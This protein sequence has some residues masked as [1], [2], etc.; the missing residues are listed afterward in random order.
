MSGPQIVSLVFALAI[1]A[2]LFEL[3][4]RHRLREK[5]ALI[6]STLSV[7]AIIG[8]LFP[9]LLGAVATAL[10]LQLPSN[11]LFLLAIVVLLG[12][13]LQFSYELGRSEERVRTLAEEV[14]LLR[15]RIDEALRE[16]R[17]AEQHD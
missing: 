6:W 7:A 14:A 5:Y 15:L 4:R 1:M 10:G 13:T 16:I 12:L 2:T 3:L 8:A 17:D 9:G 11:L